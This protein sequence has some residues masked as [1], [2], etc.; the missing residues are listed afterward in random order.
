MVAKT[1]KRIVVISILFSLLAVV[2]CDRD[3]SLGE[4]IYNPPV[5]RPYQLK[6]PERFPLPSV[7]ATNLTEEGIALGKRLFFDPIL[8]A[9]GTQ[10]CGSCHNQE[11]GFTDNG[12]RLSVGIDG[13]EGKRNAMPIFNLAWANS[14]FWDG[15]SATL[16]IQALAPVV[17]PLEMHD[18]WPNVE[19][20]L[21]NHPDYPELFA[22]VYGTDRIDS[23]LVT[24]ALAEYE[25]TLISKTSEFD[26]KLDI[27]GD[28]RFIQ[29][30]DPDAKRG[31]EI[32]LREPR[33]QATDLAGGDCF[34]CHALNA[35]NTLTTLNQMENN[36][37]DLEP[38]SGFARVSK[39]ASDI[40]KFKTPSLRNLSFTAPYMHD[41][42]FATLE[43][44]VDFYNDG[45]EPNSPNISVIMTKD[46]GLANGLFLSDEEKRQL[47]AFLKTLDDRDFI[48]DPRHKPE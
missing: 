42:R 38:D 8:S 27:Y 23:N 36:G 25:M 13:L 17:D 4:T 48:T 5:P 10:S 21:N 46:K 41:G 9:D 28:V 31:M 45:V 47:I 7:P 34:H 43:E 16:E 11:F 6:F 12:R 15:R 14:F 22:F 32:F 35:Q 37:L 1:L 30:D 44:V 40:G 33:K 24:R 18:T 19:E 26:K 2:S 20:K 39:Q 29:F 3:E